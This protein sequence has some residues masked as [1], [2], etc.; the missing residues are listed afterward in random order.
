MWAAV[1][2][3]SCDPLSPMDEGIDIQDNSESV[4]PIYVFITY[5]YL[6]S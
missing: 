4:Y 5:N 2:L 3:H 1:C 6:W